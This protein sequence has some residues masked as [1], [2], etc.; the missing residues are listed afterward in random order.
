MFSL[1]LSHHPCHIVVNKLSL[2][3]N[4]P[5]LPRHTN[6]EPGVMPSE[7]C[8]SQMHSALTQVSLE[9]WIE[10]NK[11]N[12]NMYVILLCSVHV[13]HAGRHLVKDVHLLLVRNYNIFACFLTICQHLFAMRN[14]IKYINM[15]NIKILL[16]RFDI[17]ILKFICEQ[18]FKYKYIRVR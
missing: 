13:F 17:L 6:T 12:N 1:L 5:Q 11:Q 8:L 7:P 3:P 10:E 18:L 16:K 4:W 9:G 15:W 2:T 14:K